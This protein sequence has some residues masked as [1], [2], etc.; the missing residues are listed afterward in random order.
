MDRRMAEPSRWM[1]KLREIQ[2]ILIAG[3][4]W[5][6]ASGG[7]LLDFYSGQLCI[8]ESRR[9]LVVRYRSLDIIAY[10]EHEARELSTW[11]GPPSEA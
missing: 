9:C 5:L 3:Q 10:S 7:C 1:L 4:M 8:L 2:L 11:F 6:V